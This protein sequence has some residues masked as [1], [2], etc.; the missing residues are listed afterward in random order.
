MNDDRHVVAP[1]GGLRDASET[2]IALREV[3]AAVRTAGATA[4]LVGLR[5]HAL[6]PFDPDERDAGDA[7]EIK[8]VSQKA[9]AVVLGTPNYHGSYSAPLKNTLD[10]CGR[11]EFEGTTVGLLVVAGGDFPTPALDHLRTVTR[12]L[13]AW[14]LPTRDHSRRLL[15][16]RGRRRRAVP[17]R[18]LPGVGDGRLR[19]PTGVR[20]SGS[21][22]DGMRFHRQVGN[23]A[24][25][26]R[27]SSSGTI[28][29]YM[30]VFPTAQR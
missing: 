9:D 18:H 23:P 6:P 8:R 5:K 22:T 3:L 1:C 24:K 2:R 7:S 30:R 29:P 4:D 21:V 26:A 13:N 19:E 20:A 25:P 15:P 28:N 10:Y 16:R 27:R 17:G 12:T 14:T 11:D